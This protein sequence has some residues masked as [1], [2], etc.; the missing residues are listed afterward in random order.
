MWML[1]LSTFINR[2]GTMVIFF[3]TLFLVQVRGWSA[4]EAATALALQGAG[5]LAAGPFRGWFADRF[6]HRF[7]LAWSLGIEAGVLLL[8]PHVHSRHLLLALITLLSAATQAYWP[9]SMAFIT[10]L[11]PPENRKQAFVLHR[12]ATALGIAVGPALGGVIVHHAFHALFWIDAI[13]TL[14]GLAI[15]LTGIRVPATPLPPGHPSASAWRDHRLILLL[16]CPWCPPL[17]TPWPPWRP[18]IAGVST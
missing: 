12:L 9:A 7:T 13:T 8:I 10:D 11:V 2:M 15:I 1:A 14:G 6:G 5:A 3:F 16:L 17:A 18:P 4:G